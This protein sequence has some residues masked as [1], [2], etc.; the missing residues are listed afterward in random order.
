MSHPRSEIVGA[1]S[2]RILILKS[3]AAMFATGHCGGKVM[4]HATLK[5]GILVLA[6]LAAGCAT[7][8]TGL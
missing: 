5:F 2:P 1:D 7:T 4:K 3:P 8:G 6:V